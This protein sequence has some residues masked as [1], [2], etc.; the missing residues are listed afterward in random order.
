MNVRFVIHPNNFATRATR[1]TTLAWRCT[2]SCYP[3]HPSLFSRRRRKQKR[4]RRP[5]V[6]KQGNEKSEMSAIVIAVPSAAAG[7]WRTANGNITASVLLL[8]PS[9]SPASERSRCSRWPPPLLLCSVSWPSVFSVLSVSLVGCLSVC[10]SV[11]S[12]CFRPSSEHLFIG[13]FI[14]SSIY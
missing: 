9:R 14:R 3:V 12:V 8:L 1:T 13:L 5:N 10:L 11:L 7:L 6:G 2:N 4:K